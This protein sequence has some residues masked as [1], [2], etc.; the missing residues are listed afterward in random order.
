MTQDDDT[1]L[2][3]E[4]MHKG[5]GNVAAGLLVASHRRGEVWTE[6]Q[7]H[8]AKTLLDNLERAK[9]RAE[10]IIKQV[11]PVEQA[12]V[13]AEDAQAKLGK[14]AAIRAKLKLRNPH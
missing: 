2:A 12:K 7:Q 10:A 5:L 1:I 3:L 14:L 9:R 6:G 4:R 13:A 8:V 11:S